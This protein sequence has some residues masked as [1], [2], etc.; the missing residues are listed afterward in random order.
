MEIQSN[1]KTFIGKKRRNNRLT[2]KLFYS[3]KKKQNNGMYFLKNKDYYSKEDW[4]FLK[5][6]N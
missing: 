3:V 4:V 2:F 5:Q 1:Y 6:V